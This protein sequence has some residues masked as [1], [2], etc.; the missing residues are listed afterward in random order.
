[1]S[2]ETIDRLDLNTIRERANS[3]SSGPWSAYEVENSEGIWYVDDLAGGTMDTAGG[4]K[5][6]DAVFIAH[7]RQDVPSLLDALDRARA[8]AVRLEQELAQ[9]NSVDSGLRNTDVT[10]L[11]HPGTKTPQTGSQGRTEPYQC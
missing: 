6:A 2:T 8:T 11:G 1:M 4:L 5:E 10:L 7:A 3:A 9:V